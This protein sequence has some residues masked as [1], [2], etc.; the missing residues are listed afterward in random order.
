MKS[1]TVGEVKTHFSELIS[2]VKKGEKVK[3]LYGKS[4]KPVAMLVPLED[5]K[6]D[7]EIGLLDGK[8]SFTM[9]GDGKITEEEFLGI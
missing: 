1:L 5:M 6:K 2:L 3:I 9:L 8:A 4:K 7:R